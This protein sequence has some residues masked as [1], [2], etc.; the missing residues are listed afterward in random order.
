LQLPQK[1]PTQF[2]HQAPAVNTHS[3]GYK[4]C[5]FAADTRPDSLEKCYDARSTLGRIASLAYIKKLFTCQPLTAGFTELLGTFFLFQITV[6]ENIYFFK[7]KP[8]C[9][10][11]NIYRS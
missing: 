10:V 4:F 9:Y 5:C 6:G 7:K 3:I 8:H 11:G 1:Q 2:G